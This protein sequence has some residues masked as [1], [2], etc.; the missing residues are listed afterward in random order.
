MFF[1]NGALHTGVDPSRTAL[2]ELT[3]GRIV[4]ARSARLCP[5]HNCVTGTVYWAIQRMG[6]GSGSL[7]ALPS[8]PE[9]T[10]GREEAAGRMLEQQPM[11]PACGGRGGRR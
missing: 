8:H 3:S 1:Q 7:P 2:H 9:I 5:S 6:K 11:W 10:A 4:M